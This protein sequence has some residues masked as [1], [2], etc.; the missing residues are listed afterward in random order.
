MYAVYILRL[1]FAM[2]ELTLHSSLL[3]YMV[4]NLH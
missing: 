2:A 1:G 4:A 3:F